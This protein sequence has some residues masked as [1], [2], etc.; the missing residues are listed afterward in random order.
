MCRFFESIKLEDGDFKRLNYHQERVKNAINDFYPNVKP[1]D[2]AE[3]LQKTSFPTHGIYKCRIVFDT[4]IRQVEFIQFV[5]REVNSLRLV[6]IN[7]KSHHYKLE[8][9]SEITAAFAQRGDCDDIIMV[10]NGLITDT[11]YSN[12][13]FFDGKNWLTP[14]IPLI[15]GVNRTEL[16]EQQILIEKDITPKELLNFRQVSLFNAMNEF[17]SI[18]LDISA[19][20]Q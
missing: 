20:Q 15:Y 10:K 1:F 6:E 7:I 3:F 8:D 4:E 5:K 13:A 9:R 19:I 17:G 16:L 12:L 18:K 2:L 11:S 14:R